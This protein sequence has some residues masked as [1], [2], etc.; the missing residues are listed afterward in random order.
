MPR[1]VGRHQNAVSPNG[2]IR[3]STDQIGHAVH[4]ENELIFAALRVIETR[5]ASPGESLT[6]PDKVKQYLSIRL[7]ERSYESFMVLFLDVKNRLI[8]TVELF[9]GTLTQ[10][11]V[12]P[13]EVVKEA[14]LRNAAGVILAHNHPSGEP[15]PSAADRA[16]THAL[17]AALALVDVRVLDHIIV[18]G[19]RQYSFAE[20]GVL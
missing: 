15:E 3:P 7:G 2:D 4:Q 9:R 17:K 8:E 11:S 13:R 5:L 14:L 20:H 12:Y 6:S 10:T 16:L 18:A 1:T 19:I